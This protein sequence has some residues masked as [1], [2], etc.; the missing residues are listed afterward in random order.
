M[1]STIDRL[2]RVLGE[3]EQND[4]EPEGSD[5]DLIGQ[6]EKMAMEGTVAAPAPAPA[7]KQPEKS[8]S[9]TLIEQTLER[10]LRPGEVSLDELERAFRETPG[11]ETAASK[12]SLISGKTAA[13]SAA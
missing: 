1:L 4:Q 9:G 8:T 12:K 13:K 11:P 3:L 7:P 6:L 10:P 2:K 5:A